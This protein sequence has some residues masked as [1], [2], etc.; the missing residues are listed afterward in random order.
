MSRFLVRSATASSWGTEPRHT[1]ST[2]IRCGH[3]GGATSRS[4]DRRGRTARDSNT[5]LA[6]ADPRTVRNTWNA[7]CRRPRSDWCSAGGDHT[8]RSRTGRSSR[9]VLAE[10]GRVNPSRV[11]AHRIGPRRRGSW[12]GRRRFRLV[13]CSLVAG[14]IRSV[15]LVRIARVGTGSARNG[16]RRYWML[17]TIADFGRLCRRPSNI[18]GMAWVYRLGKDRDGCP[19]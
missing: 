8:G 12:V 16:T 7:W 19:G 15:R 13:D 18:Q 11:R 9:R 17:R 1:G 6:G 4:S 3:R 14:L 10:L 2:P 5:R